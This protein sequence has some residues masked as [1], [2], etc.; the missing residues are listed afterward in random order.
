MKIFN[1]D[2]FSFLEKKFDAMLEMPFLVY[3]FFYISGHDYTFHS[4]KND[5]RFFTAAR[6]RGGISNI[7]LVSKTLSFSNIMMDEYKKG[8]KHY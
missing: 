8:T 4:K 5:R 7:D 6:C 1:E 3:D 2:D